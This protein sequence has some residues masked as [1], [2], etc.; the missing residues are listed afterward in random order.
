MRTGLAVLIDGGI[1]AAQGQDA[2][3]REAWQTTWP[4][5]SSTVDESHSASRHLRR[6]L[7]PGTR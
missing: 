2:L 5:L 6:L 4:Q 3:A 7:Q 1:L